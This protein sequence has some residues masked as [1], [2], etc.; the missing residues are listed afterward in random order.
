MNLI[1][2]ECLNSLCT[3]TATVIHSAVDTVLGQH[4]KNGSRMDLPD[5]F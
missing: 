4:V 5:N 2:Y 1:P 3:N